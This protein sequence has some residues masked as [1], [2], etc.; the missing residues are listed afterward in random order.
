[1]GCATPPM[2][3]RVEPEQLQQIKQARP[4]PYPHL[5][6]VVFRALQPVA[7]TT[8]AVNRSLPPD[9]VQGNALIEF[10]AFSYL[11][12]KLDNADSLWDVALSYSGQDFLQAAGTLTMEQWFAS[13]VRDCKQME[14]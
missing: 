12:R 4:N 14:V 11:F 1:M 13:G 3:I 6:N 5:G 7:I 9:E 8:Y 2:D 10:P